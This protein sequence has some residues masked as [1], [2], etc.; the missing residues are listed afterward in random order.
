VV[1]RYI[2]MKLTPKEVI[3]TLRKGGKVEG[4]ILLEMI[5][6][7]YSEEIPKLLSGD[8][9]DWIIKGAESSDIRIKKFVLRFMRV[10]KDHP[11]IRTFLCDQW[12]QTNDFNIQISLMWRMLD[13]PDLEQEYHTKIYQCIKDHF[14]EFYDDIWKATTQRL[15]DQRYP[16]SK[17]WIYL[18]AACAYKD[19]GKVREL[20]AQY[21]A[22]SIPFVAKVAEELSSLPMLTA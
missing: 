15:S 7:P 19:K 4:S 20:L 14:N 9:I 11:G 17:K 12:D 1:G 16:E 8:D 2:T 13:Y 22:S 6:W 10:V 5:Q 21:Q 3:D 18:C